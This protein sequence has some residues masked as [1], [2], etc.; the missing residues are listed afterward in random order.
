MCK[1]QALE[2]GRGA[3]RALIS[4]LELQGCI[5]SVAPSVPFPTSLVVPFSPQISIHQFTEQLI[6]SSDREIDLLPHLKIL[7]QSIHIYWALVFL[8]NCMFLP[9]AY[10]G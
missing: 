8:M 7:L 4:F 1:D 5:A 6:D 10:F 2:T 3:L 9:F